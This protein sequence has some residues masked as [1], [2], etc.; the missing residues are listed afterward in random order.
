MPKFMWDGF[1]TNWIS[2]YREGVEDWM[3]GRGTD[4]NGQKRHSALQDY[5]DGERLSDRSEQFYY[6][7]IPPLFFLRICSP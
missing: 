1:Q 7:L 2:I 3:N 5:Y 6:C 4:H